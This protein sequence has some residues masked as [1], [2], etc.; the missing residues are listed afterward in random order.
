MRKM[1]IKKIIVIFK[2]HLDI[3]FTDF[4]EK[5]VQKY[6]GEFIPN[7]LSVAKQLR[8][9]NSDARLVWTTG[10]WLIHEYL[11]THTGKEKDAII[12]GIENGDIR[13]HG[14]PFTTH[15]ELMS[16]KLFEY[17]LS[18]SRSLDAQFGKRTIAAKMTDVPGHTRAI[19]PYLRKAGIEFLHIGVN[20][21]STVP[22]VPPIFRWKAENGELLTVMYQ[23]D[24]GEFSP[25]GD[26]DTAVYFAH[27]GDNIGVQSVEDIKQIFADLKEKMPDAE[28]VAGD[29]NDLALAV[30]KI[31]DTLPVVTDEIGDSWIHGVGTDPKKVSQFRALE[32]LYEN[33]T[34][35]KDKDALARGLVMIPEHTWGMDVKLHLADHNHYDRSSFEQVRGVKENYLNMEAS[36]RE[37]RNYLYNAIKEMSETGQQEALRFI[38][39]ASRDEASIT[40]MKEYK[41][42]ECITFD[43]YKI[44]FNK[45]GE[46]D[47]LSKGNCIIADEE[48]RLIHICYEQFS[49][50]DYKRFFSQYNRLNVEWAR[51]DNMKIGMENAASE[52]YLFEPCEAKVYYDREHV[53][54]L[55]QFDSFAYEKCGC[56]KRMDMV[57]TPCGGNLSFDVAWFEKPANRIAEAI[58]VGFHPIASNKKISKL[59]TLIEP[60]RVVPKGQCRLHATDYGVVYDELSIETI[61]TALVAP[62]EPSL[63]NFC[64]DKSRDSKVYFN[65]YNNIWGTNFPMWYEEDA[66]FRFV[67]AFEESMKG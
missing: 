42:G 30:R 63:L 4:S 64:D 14:L 56:P 18:I 31:E 32:R 58:W 15:T 5:V 43:D 51:E 54:V 21:A 41:I 37:Q 39:E 26:S 1:S 46:L 19:I 25:I 11:R 49:G 50:A 44:S 28:I 3:G 2:T 60:D 12:H 52:R 59:S 29:L 22:E 45:K 34:D 38:A 16:S 57:I 61:D 48:H 62:Q 8:E 13:W 33:F 20:P 27:T 10:S 66:R 40:G 23:M 35:E 47:F 55:Y 24:Y 53:V 65:L 7:S 9:S 17:G 36:W 6:M 67:L